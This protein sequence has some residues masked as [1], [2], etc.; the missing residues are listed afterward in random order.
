MLPFVSVY[1]LFISFYLAIITL[2]KAPQNVEAE[3]RDRPDLEANLDEG[4]F[5][6]SDQFADRVRQ[7]DKRFN[8]RLSGEK[9]RFVEDYINN[10]FGLVIRCHRAGERD[11]EWLALCVDADSG[12]N[13]VSAAIGS[14]TG[15]PVFKLNEMR[16]N[17]QEPMLVDIVEFIKSP[18]ERGVF[19]PS[20]VRFYNIKN[21]RLGLWEGHIYRRI[22][23]SGF[24]DT[25]REFFPRFVSWKGRPRQAHATDGF[26]EPGP[27]I[28]GDG[29][30]VVD[31]VSSMENKF[32]WER[33]GWPDG[34]Y[35]RISI[36][37]DGEK[38]GIMGDRLFNEMF[39]SAHVFLG[40]FDLEF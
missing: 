24:I 2:T 28:I 6:L 8:D 17:Q 25:V 16:N 3:P 18:N 35:G 26:P 1:F 30:K 39:D 27:K 31:R 15:E 37:I 33:M 38:I 34:D 20:F 23:Q 14:N 13:G 4:F 10:R 12:K 11:G 22:L 29:I 5:E 7:I 9:I 40:P 36:I 19:I 21:E 32:D